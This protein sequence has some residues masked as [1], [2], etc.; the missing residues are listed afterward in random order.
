MELH[1]VRGR[2][3]QPIDGGR[4]PHRMVVDITVIRLEFLGGQLRMQANQV[5]G[6][7]LHRFGGVAQ[8]GQIAFHLV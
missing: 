3:T 6:D 7:F 4:H 1:R 5:L 8:R 2:D